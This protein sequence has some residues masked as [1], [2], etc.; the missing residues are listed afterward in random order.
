MKERMMIKARTGWTG[1]SKSS[2]RVFAAIVIVAAA[3]FLFPLVW[4]LLT[5][6][7]PRADLY[8]DIPT[9]I[10]GAL[11]PD[12]YLYILSQQSFLHFFLN[13]VVVTTCSVFIVLISSIMGGYAFGMRRFKGQNV[14]F[15]L[16]TLVL[17]VPYIMYLIPIFVMEMYTN[18]RNTWLGLIL[19]YVALNLPWGL[20]IMRGAFSTIP[21][22]IKDSATIDG[23]GEPRFVFGICT[24]ILKPAMA[25]TTIITFV[26]VWEEFLFSSTINMKN[27]TLPVYFKFLLLETQ[28]QEWG[29]VGAVVMI[30]I[31]PVLVLFI[32]FRN[33][34][35]KGLSEGMLKG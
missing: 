29:K 25:A 1:R 35:I 13:S 23:C 2:R 19:P 11:V 17:A 8:K 7:R 15:S 34:F 24:P 27:Y 31:L 18:L 28:G 12:N 16:V 6:L 4:M 30:T 5:S 21:I 33:F 26:F 22:D 9:L 32:V 20:L 10:P 3:A 14:L